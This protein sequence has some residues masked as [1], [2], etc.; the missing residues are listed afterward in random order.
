MEEETI[1]DYTEDKIKGTLEDMAKESRPGFWQK[2]KD[3][4]IEKSEEEPEI[5]G[6]M[7]FDFGVS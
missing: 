6:Q 1:D 3:Y 2:V 4:A 7:Q 5:P